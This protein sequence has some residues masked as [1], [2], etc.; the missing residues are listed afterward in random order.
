MN[1][2]YSEIS[3]NL[4]IRIST[5]EGGFIVL[6][7]DPVYRDGIFVQPED[8]DGLIIQLIEARQQIERLRSE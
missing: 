7:N 4:H 1:Y 6:T 3:E 8:V 2:D 5:A